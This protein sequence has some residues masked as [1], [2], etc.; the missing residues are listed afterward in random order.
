MKVTGVSAAANAAIRHKQEWVV[1]NHFTSGVFVLPLGAIGTQPHA[2]AID[3]K[4]RRVYDKA[5][6]VVLRLSAQV[7]ALICASGNAL[8]RIVAARRIKPLNRRK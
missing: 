4:A 1:F 3:T 2:I 7:L 6:P 8:K 5:Q